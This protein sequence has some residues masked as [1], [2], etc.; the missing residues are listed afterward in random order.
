[1]VRATST[2][3][4]REKTA[5]QEGRSRRRRAVLGVLGAA[6]FLDGLDADIVAV[7]LP[8]FRQ[9]LGIGFAAAQWAVAGYSLTTA[10]LLITGGRLGTLP[11]CDAG[12]GAGVIHTPPRFGSAAGIAAIGAVF[13][14]ALAGTTAAGDACADAMGAALW[15]V[16]GVFLLVA[17]MSR[18]PP[19]RGGA[20][21]GPVAPL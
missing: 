7:S 4:Q 21:D 12:A 10:V 2:E 6:P 16:P 3:T 17:A 14:G 15:C 9:A 18:C 1:M 8:G 20:A 19:R 13:F 11:S 5:E